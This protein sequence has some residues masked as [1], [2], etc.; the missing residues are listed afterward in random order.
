MI[1]AVVAVVVFFSLFAGW[2]PPLMLAA[3][4]LLI[5]LFFLIFGRHHHD[6]VLT[7]DLYA[8][9]SRLCRENAAFKTAA[10]LLLLIGCICCRSPWPP[11]LLFGFMSVATIMGG[12][13][14]VH[15]YVSLLGLPAAFLLLS[16]L[17]LLWDFYR[18]Y[19]QQ[20][21]LSFPFLGGWLAVTPATQSLAGLVMSRAL[22]AV[23]CLYFLSLSTPIP[24]LIA[25]CRRV[26]VPEVIIELAVLIY[27]YIFILFSTFHDMKDAAASR[28]GYRGPKRSLHTTGLVYGG[29]LASSFRRAGV[30]FDAMES[31]GYAG[32]IAFLTPKKN[33]TPQIIGLLGF[34]LLGMLTG[35]C[36]GF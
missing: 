35:L 34:P 23:G 24:E 32:R 16:G 3:V 33:V 15:G 2:M 26:H 22:G 10:C 36:L 27:R 20:A 14:S 8:R 21:V 5:G 12:G 31:R 25:V 11:L 28:L 29:L 17:T 4:C 13:I 19:P 18:I 1:T 30:C 6:H 9:H 7:M